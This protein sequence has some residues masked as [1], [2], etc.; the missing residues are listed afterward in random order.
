MQVPPPP[1]ADGKNIL[2]FPR[3]L[4]KVLPEETSTLLSPF[5]CKETGPDG[6]SFALAPKSIPTKI[7][8]TVKKTTILAITTVY[9]IFKL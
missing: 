9:S 4:N 6:K 1:H 7:N 2:L 3:V 5:I 8:V